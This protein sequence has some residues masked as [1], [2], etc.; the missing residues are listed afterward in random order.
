MESKQTLIE[1]IEGAVLREFLSDQ[2][3]DSVLL[4]F[5]SFTLYSRD[6]DGIGCH[7]GIDRS[8]Y[9]DLYGGAEKIISMNDWRLEDLL[10]DLKEKDLQ[11]ILSGMQKVTPSDSQKTLSP[12]DK[13]HQPR[14]T[15][16]LKL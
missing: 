8:L 1:K 15:S 13:L 14:H 5:P 4:S 9:F 12:K 11:S 2:R 7:Y 16:K 10:S 6:F 3:S